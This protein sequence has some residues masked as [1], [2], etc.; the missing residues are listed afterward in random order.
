VNDPS[1][2]STDRARL[3]ITAD[4]FGRDAACTAAIAE[5]LSDGAVTSTSIMANGGHFEEACALARACGLIDRIGVHLSLDEGPALSSEMAPYTDSAGQLCVR[6][7]LMPL[8]P[9]F[10]RAVEAELS[11]QVDRVI[12]AG[13]RPTHL[14][15][16]R[17][18]HTAFPIGRLVV[19][20]ARRYHIAY[21]RPARNLAS[22]RSA[23]ANAY[24]WMFNRY[25]A[26]C[27]STADYFG[28]IVD[29]YHRSDE[30]GARGLIE[31]MIHLD[32]SPRGLDQRR[33]VK[34]EGFLRFLKNFQLV[35][36]AQTSH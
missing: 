36:H 18:I 3:I 9:S 26:A 8:G 19:R 33:L 11:A 15:S 24:K 22:R 12:A 35:G 27:V 4:D 17:H 25:L 20:L 1:R 2:Q 28:D 13:I 34:S 29:F 5:S 31:C 21:V 16:H 23:A 14:D 32:D 10:S 7:S 6:R 30:H